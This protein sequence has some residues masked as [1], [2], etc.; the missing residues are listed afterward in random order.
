[1]HLPVFRL[2]HTLQDWPDCWLE[3]PEGPSLRKRTVR[4]GNTGRI[5]AI[6]VGDG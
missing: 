1:M 5:Q 4:N 3:G 6:S 2:D